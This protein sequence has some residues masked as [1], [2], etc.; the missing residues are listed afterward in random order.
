MDYKR[1]NWREDTGK[2]PWLIRKRLAD[3][4]CV[5]PMNSDN[6]SDLCVGQCWLL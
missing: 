2:T 4:G 3:R 5:A 1:I 6:D